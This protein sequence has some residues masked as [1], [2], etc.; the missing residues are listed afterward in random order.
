MLTWFNKTS[1][2][3]PHVH[4]LKNRHGT[5]NFWYRADDFK[6]RH[7][8][9]STCR[10]V[11]VPNVMWHQCSKFYGCRGYLR[12]LVSARVNK[13]QCQKFGVPCRFFSTCKWGLNLAASL[14]FTDS[15]VFRLK[16]KVSSKTV[17]DSYYRE[18]SGGPK[19]KCRP[20]PTGL[21]AG[22]A[23]EGR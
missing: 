13:E 8:Q 21:Q 17:Y 19:K 12:E 5:P 14:L 3:K 22:Y 2:F 10:R 7:S 15:T 4:A 11:S 9:F 18:K 1:R 23:P 6:A 20:E 16:F